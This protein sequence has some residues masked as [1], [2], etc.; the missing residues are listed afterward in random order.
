MTGS[1][2]G[3][4]TQIQFND[5]GVFGAD[6]NLRFN[7]A[8]AVFTQNGG[9]HVQDMPAQPPGTGTSKVLYQAT[10]VA[11][12]NSAGGND[13]QSFRLVITSG[14]ETQGPTPQPNYYNNVFGYGWNISNAFTALDP[15]KPAGSYRIESK[16]AQGLP[17][18]AFAMEFHTAIT[19]LQGNE[20]R[21]FSAFAPHSD[22]DCSQSAVLLSGNTQVMAD[23]LGAPNVIWDFN[24]KLITLNAANRFY[25]ATNNVPV[26]TQINGAG[27]SSVA[28]P[29]I[30]DLGQTVFS[31]ALT[32]ASSGG[33]GRGIV[34]TTRGVNTDVLTGVA[35][36]AAAA[37]FTLSCGT[38]AT[39]KSGTYGVDANG[40]LVIGQSTTGGGFYIDHNNDAFFR[41]RSN[42]GAIVMHLRAGSLAV[43]GSYPL[44]QLHVTCSTALTNAVQPM[45]R[46]SN[47]TSA[48]PASGLGAGLEFD[49]T[50]QPGVQ[51]VVAA[52]NGVATRVTAGQEVGD[53]VI[54]TMSAGAAAAE[55]LRISAAAVTSQA[56]VV[57][58]I[59]TVANLPPPNA[60]LAGARANVSDASAPAFLANAVG[61]GAVFSPV[62]C[63]GTRWIFG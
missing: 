51:K 8:T 20:R 26:F 61:G 52:V 15:T 16:F 43:G 34:A 18:S 53:V 6:A 46:L 45:A 47:V 56:P 13:S 39:L 37:S 7:K 33:N 40:N 22:T 12:I 27:N 44:R 1:P 31:G 57:L 32:S 24:G 3:S 55:R 10:P 42:G 11:G 58:P 30:D 36:N 63:T 14:Y 60:A 17:N 28:L 59:F 29:Y 35:P 50:V 19:T 2:A 4:D 5:A 25:A 62:T 23:Y 49:V 54:A 38:G 9:M 48:A 21:V 41:N